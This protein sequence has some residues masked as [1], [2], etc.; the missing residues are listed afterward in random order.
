LLSLS[1]DSRSLNSPVEGDISIYSHP[2]RKPLGGDGGTPGAA[3]K[4]FQFQVPADASSIEVAVRDLNGRGGRHFVYRLRIS[5]AAAPDFSLAL[6]ETRI[7]IPKNGRTMVP[8]QVDRRGYAGP[9][10]LRLEGEGV[11]A[12][13]IT[14]APKEIPADGQSRKLFVTFTTTGS[15]PE[16]AARGLRIVGESVGVKPA[17]RRAAVIEVPNQAELSGF[18]DRVPVGARS[19]S[20]LQV[21]LTALP[22]EVYK[23]SEVAWP[24]VLTAASKKALGVE[25]DAWVRLSL[26]STE[27]GR[28][29]APNKQ[30][31]KP[32]VAARPDQAMPLASGK[33]LLKVTVPTDV[34]EP[35]IEFVV[36]AD[37]VRHPYASGV[38]AT[39]YSEPF[40]VLVK[41]KPAPEKA[42]P[43]KAPAPKPAPPK[44]AG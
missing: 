6:L 15:P 41:D 35:A 19:A 25:P 23:G 27:A 32:L 13:S 37:V 22:H 16:A 40:Q 26:V 12:G 2:D 21:D 4:G 20:P 33:G 42:N 36:K 34:A 43:P 24:I 9:I 1:L 7:N 28:L 18:L 17:I 14:I 31:F 5:P 11:A 39:T 8:L 10:K 38:F 30:R 3:G 29:V 44:K